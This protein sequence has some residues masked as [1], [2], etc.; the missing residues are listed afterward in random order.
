M[1]P[2]ADDKKVCPVGAKKRNDAINFPGFDEVAG[3]LNRVPAALGD[4]GL[5]KF[6]IMPLP[7]RFDTLF[8]LRGYCDDESRICGRRLNHG[9][10]L[11]RRAKQLA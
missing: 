10:G 4:G 1:L 2:E 9:D 7:I 5:H 8:H 11:Q 3:Y 6:L